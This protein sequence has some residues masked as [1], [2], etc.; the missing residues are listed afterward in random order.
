MKTKI[1]LTILC[2]TT[3]FATFGQEPQE[4]DSQLDIMLRLSNFE[5]HPPFRQLKCGL[6]I[7]DAGDIAFKDIC[8]S[9]DYEG[10]QFDSLGNAAETDMEVVDCY[11]TWAYNRADSINQYVSA[12][13]TVV[14]TATFRILNG[15]FF[16][17]K[18]HIYSFVPMACG[19][20][21]SVNYD[22]DYKTFRAIPNEQNLDLARDKNHI[23][24]RLGELTDKEIRVYEEV[25]GIKLFTQADCM[26]FTAEKFDSVTI[27]YTMDD[28]EYA[29]LT[30]A[31]DDTFIFSGN[32]LLTKKEIK[33]LNQFFVSSKSFSPP[34][35]Y[36][37][38][39]SYYRGDSV[40]INFTIDTVTRMSVLLNGERRFRGFIA[41]SFEKYL[42]SLL[43]N[44]K[45]WTKKQR[46]YEWN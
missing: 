33:K 26:N 41:K 17:D 6:W 3:V 42:T 24:D 36:R 11:L 21:I 10:I 39:I 12:L 35:M 40:A 15:C 28:R 31:A 16:K 20:H 8:C 45:I 29:I 37:I 19:G 23:Y 14:D 7:N 9:P 2:L 30:D 34:N 18:N 4:E 25:L 38:D 5:A 43:R 46:F 1:I 27:S 32:K 44:K 13:K 22:A